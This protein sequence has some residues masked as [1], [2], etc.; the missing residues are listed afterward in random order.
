MIDDLDIIDYR[1][2]WLY[3]YY[4]SPYVLY[5]TELFELGIIGL[6]AGYKL[7]LELDE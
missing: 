4:L 1:V 5:G 2:V 3:C 7:P 6:F